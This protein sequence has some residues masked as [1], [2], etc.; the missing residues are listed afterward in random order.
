[1]SVLNGRKTYLL[2]AASLVYAGAGWYAH[3]LPGPEALQIAQTALLG[4]FIRHGVR[5]G[6]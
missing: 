4:A 5:T 3:A 6:A 2:A 1:M